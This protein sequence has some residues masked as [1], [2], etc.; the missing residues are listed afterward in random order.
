[1]NIPS[2]KSEFLPG[3]SP[4]KM[5]VMLLIALALFSCPVR[6]QSQSQSSS[7]QSQPQPEKKADAAA[8]GV[9]TSEKEKPKRKKVYT[10][11]DLFSMG[12]GGISVVGDA[13][14]TASKAGAAVTG[15]G[16]KEDAKGAAGKTGSNIVPMSGED[17]AYW[18]G[19][20]KQ[21][22]DA[23][24]S[25]DQ[26]IEKTKADIKKYGAEGFDATSGFKDNVIY[27]DNRNS[28]LEELQK[29]KADLEQKLDQLQ[30]DGRKAGAPPDWFR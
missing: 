26:E 22:L 24:A 25:T 4:I 5:P 11:D 29:R 10:E 18:R 20:A 15:T 1:M 17:E 19:K 21:L 13:T 12:G 27:I 16:S 8:G 6:C 3:T 7:Q 9:Q 14:T 2:T 30:E 23:I 28:R